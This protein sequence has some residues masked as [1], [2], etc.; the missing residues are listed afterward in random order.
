MKDNLKIKKIL[1]LSRIIE[2]ARKE[3]ERM[4]ECQELDHSLFDKE[5]FQSFF[6]T[7]LLANKEE[8]EIIKDVEYEQGIF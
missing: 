3:F 5:G 8:W 4:K 6:E 2:T 7:L 1:R